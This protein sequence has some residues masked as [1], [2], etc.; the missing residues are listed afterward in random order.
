MYQVSI[1]TDKGIEKGVCRKIDI[2]DGSMILYDPA[3]AGYDADMLIL[4]LG[5]YS[6]ISVVKL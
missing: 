2:K 4:N 1:L 5:C 6:L 3:F